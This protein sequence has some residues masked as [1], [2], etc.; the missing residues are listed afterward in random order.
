M[1]GIASRSTLDCL[2]SR[3]GCTAHALRAKPQTGKTDVTKIPKRFRFR[4]DDL[5]DHLNGSTNKLLR[6]FS[7]GELDASNGSE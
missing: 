4:R 2:A 3:I 5:L 6:T 7:E 1:N